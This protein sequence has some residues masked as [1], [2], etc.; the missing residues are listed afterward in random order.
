MFQKE[1]FNTIEELFLAHG[2]VLSQW[3][4]SSLSVF[5]VPKGNFKTHAHILITG[6]NGVNEESY[7]YVIIP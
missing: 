7:K 3:V 4:V 5:R 1:I 6:F 2:S